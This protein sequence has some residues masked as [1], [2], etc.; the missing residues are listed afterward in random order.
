MPFSINDDRGNALNKKM[1]QAADSGNHSGDSQSVDKDGKKYPK[2]FTPPVDLYVDLNNLDSNTG[3]P[4]E[5]GI[6]LTKNGVLVNSGGKVSKTKG[7]GKLDLGSLFEPNLSEDE[8]SKRY[9]RK[10]YSST[11]TLKTSVGI[12][13]STPEDRL[14]GTDNNSILNSYDNFNDFAGKEF[15]HLLDYFMDGNG[16]YTVPRQIVA[17]VQNSDGTTS[18]MDHKNIY[19]GSFIRTMDDNEDPTMLGYDINIKYDESPLFNKGIEL[20]IDTISGYS[21]TESGSR[22]SILENFRSQ[23]TKFLKIDSSSLGGQTANATPKFLG[24]SGTKVYYMKNLSGLNNLVESGDG[25]KIKS[26]VDYGKDVI[27]LQFNED[28]SQNIGYL[29]SLYKSLSWSK[30]NGKQVI[31]ENLLRFDVDITITEIR[32][33]NRVVGDKS[34]TLDV[35]SDLISK[36]TYTLYECQFFFPS[37]PH[38][39]ALDMSAPKTVDTYDIRFNYKYSTMKFSKFNVG[40]TPDDTKSEYSIN[41][42]Y[43]NVEKIKANAIK[44]G[45]ISSDPIVAQLKYYKSYSQSEVKT[46]DT[47]SGDLQSIK[48]N[49]LSKISSPLAIP[50]SISSISKNALGSSLPFDKLGKDLLNAVVNVANRQILTQASLLNKTLDNIRNSIPGAGRMSA[51]TNVYY[52]AFGNYAPN[53]AP[54]QNDVINAARNFVGASIKG[55]FTQ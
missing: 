4:V 11:D 14:R 49:E 50:S 26:F 27:T 6:S 35:Y 30:L 5:Y 44:G 21:N 32:K 29:S 3:T 48:A 34:T 41:N 40:P 20:F 28:V 2:G 12:I 17:P 47:K 31:P 55:F 24:K 18:D 25:D 8:K 53:G 7:D 36:Y 39:D 9:G 33:F 37:M 52:D 42:R 54:F 51:P 1:T 22:K 13:S 23:L 43:L 19:L 38:G 10:G 15:T 45:N 46:S 16:E